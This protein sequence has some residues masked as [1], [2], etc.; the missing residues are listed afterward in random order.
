MLQR[1]AARLGDRPARHRSCAPDQSDACLGGRPRRKA[2]HASPPQGR[3]RTA[4]P[5]PE[6]VPRRC[7][8]TPHRSSSTRYPITSGSGAACPAG[9][10]EPGIQGGR[11]GERLTGIVN[12]HGWVPPC[13]PRLWRG[14]AR[15][16]LAPTGVGG[17]SLVGHPFATGG[18]PAHA[19]GVRRCPTRRPEGP[20]IPWWGAGH[21]AAGIAEAADT[22]HGGCRAARRRAR[23]TAPLHRLGEH[24]QQGPCAP[25]F[26]GALSAVC[27]V[28]VGRC[29]TRRPGE[30][31]A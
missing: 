30:G 7:T 3:H 10:G 17:A 18:R 31:W 28:G 26:G 5:W 16:R 8:P 25:R 19:V 23:H 21:G 27:L 22:R 20:A 24:P 11:G 12:A 15:Q 13:L 1:R 2:L 6:L 4:P 14:R 29:P 9:P